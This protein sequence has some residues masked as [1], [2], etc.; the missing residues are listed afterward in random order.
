MR[1]T[2]FL[3]I[4]SV[5][6]L[7]HS[8]LHT[9]G[10]VYSQPAPGAAATV[11]AVM[12]DTPFPAFGTMHTYAEFYRGF[13]IGITIFLTVEGVVFWLLGSL[14]KIQATRL[15]P[16]LAVF[17]IGYLAFSVNSYVYFFSAPVIFEVLIAMCMGLAIAT[18]GPSPSMP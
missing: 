9:I 16:I 8:V 15:R 17:L 6:T 2:V 7:I 11:A 13:G 5:L 4:A 10:G 14:A 1:P 12:R 18:S 3:R